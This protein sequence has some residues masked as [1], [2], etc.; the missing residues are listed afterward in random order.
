M[1]IKRQVNKVAQ[2]HGGVFYRRL[3]SAPVPLKF[4]EFTADIKGTA[5]HG[6]SHRLTIDYNGARML[7]MNI[8]GG[9]PLRLSFDPPI[10]IA[11]GEAEFLVNCSGFEPNEAVSAEI[12]VDFSLALFG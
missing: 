12:S 3:Q 11:R 1:R 9:E 6:R 10:V 8:T 5:G 7:E 2:P 4:R